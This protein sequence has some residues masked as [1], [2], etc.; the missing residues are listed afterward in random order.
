MHRFANIDYRLFV[1]SAMFCA[2]SKGSV[3]NTAFLFEV[4]FALIV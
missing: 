2:Y 4:D 3:L 1:F